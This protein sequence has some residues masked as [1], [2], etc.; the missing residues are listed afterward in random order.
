[1]VDLA[2]LVLFLPALMGLETAMKL[3]WL[4]VWQ[5]DFV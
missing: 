5:S 1:V 2:L 3:V 4:R